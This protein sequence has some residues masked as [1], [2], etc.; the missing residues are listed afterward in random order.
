MDSTQP[1]LPL[2]KRKPN[3][4]CDLPDCDAPFVARGMCRK[5]YM[6]WHRATP[7]E[8]RKPAPGF[9]RLTVAERFNSK[10]AQG[11]PDECWPFTGSQH[12]FGHGQFFISKDRG[13]VPAHAF[14]LEL[15]TGEPC[16][17]GMETCHH[18]DNPPCC[19][20]AH[21]YFGTRQQNVDDMW[22]RGRAKRGSRHSNAQ[23]TEEAVVLIRQRYKAG[24]FAKTL[25]AEFNV[26]EAAVTAVVLGKTWKHVGGPIHIPRSPRGLQLIQKRSAA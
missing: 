9:S 2:R 25:A 19:N 16:P 5:H 22:R 17:A 12:G 10:V 15:A 18:C 26:R 11:A 6:A 4:T 13:L 24:E 14:A 1:R 21:L 3:D 7:R 23:L 20:P 8:A